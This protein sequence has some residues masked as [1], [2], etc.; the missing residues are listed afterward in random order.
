MYTFVGIH[1]CIKQLYEV[2]FTPTPVEVTGDAE[3]THQYN[4][5]F[6]WELLGLF[7]TVLRDEKN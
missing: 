6:V 1:I 5:R 4:S 7:W 3:R 2:K